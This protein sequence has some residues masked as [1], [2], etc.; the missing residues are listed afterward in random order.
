MLLTLDNVFL[1]FKEHSNLLSIQHM[2]FSV[3]IHCL[4]GVSGSGKTSFLRLVSGRPFDV[5]VGGKLSID[6]DSF[7]LNSDIDMATYNDQYVSAMYQDNFLID[8][9]NVVENLLLPYFLYKDVYDSDEYELLIDQLNIKDLLQKE[10]DQISRGEA[11]RVRLARALLFARKI[12]IL[13]EP[14]V[15]LDKSMKSICFKLLKTWITKK[16]LI[17]FFSTH[18]QQL[19]EGSNFTTLLT[20]EDGLKI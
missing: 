4:W 17:T 13:D 1:S 8:D 10:I 20:F 7:S 3:G 12:L 14:L 9:F 5:K 16:N 6:S 19:K 15:Y 2:V 11:Q 18:D